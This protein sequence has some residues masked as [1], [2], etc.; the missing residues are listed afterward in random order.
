MRAAR[1]S[2]PSA[3]THHLTSSFQQ[4]SGFRELRNN[5]FLTA[6]TVAMEDYSTIMFAQINKPAVKNSKI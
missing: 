3:V 1:C 5:I 6:T 4:E 2:G